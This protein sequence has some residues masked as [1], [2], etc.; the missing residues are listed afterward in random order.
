MTTE[1]TQPT[2][3]PPPPEAPGGDFRTNR[4]TQVSRAKADS[5]EGRRALA[6]LCDAYYEPVAAFLRCQL[7]DAD[8]A[9]VAKA[10]VAELRV[11]YGPQ[12]QVIQAALT[13]IKALE[14]NK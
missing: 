13:R 3:C 11:E 1:T 5:L 9:R 8:A 12:H 2:P 6:E 7:R 4:W 14:Q 10:H